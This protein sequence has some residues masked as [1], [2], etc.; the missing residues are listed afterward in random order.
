MRRLATAVFGVLMLGAVLVGVPG[1]A[2]A[3][4][5]P[6]L[7]TWEGKGSRGVQISFRLVRRRGRVT[8]ARGMTVTLPTLPVLCPAGPLTAA[9]VHYRLVT[10][11]G[12]GSPPIS[13][14]HYG[15]RSSHSTYTTADLGRVRRPPAQP[16]HDG[17]ERAGARATAERVWLAAQEAALGRAPSA[18]GARRQRHV[19][20]TLDSGGTVDV[21]VSAGGA[22]STPSRRGL[23]AGGPDPGG[24]LGS[25]N[26]EEFVDR[27]GSASR[28]RWDHL[29]P[30]TESPRPGR[31]VLGRH[32]ERNRDD[33]GPM[34]V[35]GPILGLAGL[36]DDWQNV[37]I[38]RRRVGELLTEPAKSEAEAT[39]SPWRQSE[40]LDT[41]IR[42]SAM[43]LPE[44]TSATSARTRRR[45]TESS[46][47][48]SLRVGL[49]LADVNAT[50]APSRSPPE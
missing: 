17:A 47:T 3:T 12:P 15:P 46:P 33:M 25:Q 7:G 18:Q 29:R 39:F 32:S 41:S 13:I 6:R 34:R 31:G 42:P 38:A 21:H 26:A 37:L 28:V 11:S 10:Y 23:P 40:P 49:Q 14:F 30:S 9:A 16:P 1:A 19:S 36:W 27:R 44:D 8:V 50:S 48:Y 35:D 22:S 45:R 5:P 4:A 24:G 20:G 43:R 2:S